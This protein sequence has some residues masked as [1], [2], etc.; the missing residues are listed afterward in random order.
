MICEM[1]VWVDIF[2]ERKSVK[3]KVRVRIGY[4][5][6][7]GPFKNSSECGTQVRHDADL[8]RLAQL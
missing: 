1:T 6:G 8:C 4:F 2:G 7:L 5:R 3:G